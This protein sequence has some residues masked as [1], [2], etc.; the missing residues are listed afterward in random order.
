MALSELPLIDLYI[1]Q[2]FA[3][4]RDQSGDDAPR[5]TVPAR[6]ADEIAE[7]R[8]KCIKLYHDHKQREFALPHGSDLF[9]VTAIPDVTYDPIL[10]LS[11]AAPDVP[12]F[13]S[14]GL[15]DHIAHIV[16]DKHARGLLLIAGDQ[17]AGKTT[18][19]A[20]LLAERVRALGAFGLALQDPVE[21]NIRGLHG[22]GR[23]IQQ[24]VEGVTGYADAALTAVR[25]RIK[26]I[27]FGEIRSDAHGINASTA[28]D[29]ARSGCLIMATIHA[30]SM[31]QAMDRLVEAARI[32]LGN[33]A[34]KVV[35][36][37]LT[38]VL[39]QRLDVTGR[40]TRAVI[41]GL[42]FIEADDGNALRNVVRDNKLHQIDSFVQQ[43]KA[44]FL[45]QQ[46]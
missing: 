40:K 11:R 37:A 10:I 9:R 1:G 7:I 4:Y 15:P 42:S 19:M 5:L 2:D 16:T 25:A 35:A 38:A 22:D 31:E 29:L 20:V 3:D 36:D 44:R 28:I 43:Q 13:G 30:S 46:Q 41:T 32:R 17:G 6:Y 18:T 45:W 26:N 33:E 27:S 23:I 12:P 8:A 21:N 34:P 14:L 24:P 39:W